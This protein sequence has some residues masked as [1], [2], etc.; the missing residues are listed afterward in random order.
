M[1]KILSVF[2]SLFLLMAWSAQAA[3]M[4][5]IIFLVDDMGHDD[6]GYLGG[7]TRTPNIDQLSRDGMIFSNSYSGGP[8]CSPSRSAIMTGES[9]GRLWFT[10]IVYPPFLGR[11]VGP[12]T[13]PIPRFKMIAPN[14][15]QTLPPDVKTLP[16]ILKDEGYTTAI[17]GKWH[18]SPFHNAGFPTPQPKDYGFD[19]QIGW[20]SAGTAKFPPWHVDDLPVHSPTEHITDRLTDEGVKFITENKDKPFFLYLAHYSVHEPW[21]AKA[22]DIPREM[23]DFA[24]AVYLGELNAVDRSLGKVRQALS[25]LGLA[26]HT[27]IIFASDN[28]PVLYAPAQE[29]GVSDIPLGG[30]VTSLE[31]FRGEK[32]SLFEGGIRVPTIIY[33]P[34]VTAPGSTNRTPMVNYDFLPTIVDLSGH[35]LPAG[36]H[37][38][39]R[40]LV[41]ELKGGEDYNRAVYFH[42][43][44][45]MQYWLPDVNH[46]ALSEQPRS[47]I[48]QGKYKYIM[49]LDGAPDE[50]YDLEADP[51]ERTNIASTDP[52][53]LTRLKTELQA[54]QK[55]ANVQMPTPNP[56]YNGQQ[57]P[58]PIPAGVL[59]QGKLT[60]QFDELE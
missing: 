47:A 30:K 58:L 56:N 18:L 10:S 25:D 35:A 19:E 9:P 27:T 48:R 34:G 6:V 38:D 29:K 14:T 26:D 39:G 11:V 5:F 1:K 36:L 23:S 12:G 53:D 57:P 42:R 33:A 55:D 21:K 15:R 8:V 49:S 50:L 17:V 54:W 22:S 52:A 51:G 43:P 31:V 60:A 46:I 20:G 28:G 13:D 4:N 59:F 40:S 16:E 37:L 32:G 45:Y 24:N 7:K 41:P 3:P 44:D 2:L